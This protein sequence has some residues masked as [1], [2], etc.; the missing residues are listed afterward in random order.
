MLRNLQV[1][2]GAMALLIGVAAQ[3]ADETS[4]HLAPGQGLEQ[5]Q[6]SCSMCHS[7]DYIVMNSPFQDRAGWDK[8]VNKM[9]KVMGAPITP[10]DVTTIVTYLAANYGKPSAP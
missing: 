7:L 8:T 1:A 3:A 5:V 4:V 9:V 2:A 6:V 10:D